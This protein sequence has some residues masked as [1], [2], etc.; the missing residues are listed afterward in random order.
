MHKQLVAY[1]KEHKH[2]SVPRGYKEDSQLERWVNV[3]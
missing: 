1:K 3:Q 2:T